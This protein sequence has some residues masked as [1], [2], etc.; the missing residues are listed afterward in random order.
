MKFKLKATPQEW[1]IFGLFAVLLLV[2]VSILVNNVVSFSTYGTF[3]GLNPFEALITNLPAVLLIYFGVMIFLFYS[4]KDF[5]F[6]KE[7]G[8]GLSFGKKDS[9]GFSDWCSDREMK[10]DL[11]E[12]NVKDSTY[13]Y[14]GFQL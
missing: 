1:M 11:S 12:I 9:K 4:V 14:G 3:A 8:F 10:K 13:Q 6:D 2:V 5:F 7:S